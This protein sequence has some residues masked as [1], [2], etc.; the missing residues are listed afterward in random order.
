MICE[1]D[2]K[3]LVCGLERHTYLG[4]CSSRQIRR[5][6]LQLLSQWLVLIDGWKRREAGPPKGWHG[7]AMQR[8]L[9]PLSHV[10]P[11]SHPMS[12]AHLLTRTYGFFVSEVI[13]GLNDH[14]TLDLAT[15]TSYGRCSDHI[16]RLNKH[17]KGRPPH[18]VTLSCTCRT[19]ANARLRMEGRE[20][21]KNDGN[22]QSL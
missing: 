8:L 17:D 11:P 2:W 19:P 16:S 12:R 9:P 6:A 13:V 22:R 5:P 18:S 7:G 20:G 15:G 1:G 21:E 4:I 14:G 10:G 3:V